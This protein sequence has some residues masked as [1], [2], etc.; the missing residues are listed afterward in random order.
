METR[1]A[2]GWLVL[3][4]V[5]LA[6][7][8]FAVPAQKDGKGGTALDSLLKM[9]GIDGSYAVTYR[10]VDGKAMTK[11]DFVAAVLQK[12]MTFDTEHDPAS[13]TAGLRLNAVDSV[14]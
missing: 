5:A 3:A 12:H 14:R 11:A 9:Q 8:G 10:N 1:R 2:R 7:A 13:H 4:G 6:S